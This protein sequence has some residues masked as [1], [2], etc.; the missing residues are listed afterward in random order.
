MTWPL[1]TMASLMTTI[2]V[3]TQL[4][5]IKKYKKKA[6]IHFRL[7]ST[8]VSPSTTTLVLIHLS[9]L[10]KYKKKFKMLFRL[11]LTLVFTLTTTL[12]LIQLSMI[13]KYYTKLKMRFN[14]R[15]IS[16]PFPLPIRLLLA[17]SLRI[18]DR[19]H[20]TMPSPLMKMLVSIRLSSMTRLRKMF[21]KVWFSLMWNRNPRQSST[22][23][24]MPFLLKRTTT[25]WRFVFPDSASLSTQAPHTDSLC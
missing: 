1:S 8:L 11:L 16:P 18:T 22:M 6:N 15:E 25:P 19:P 20:L 7:L 2:L 10:K 9:I 23:I 5:T 4:L 13:I 21:V 14:R 3:P 12:V 24:S 17:V